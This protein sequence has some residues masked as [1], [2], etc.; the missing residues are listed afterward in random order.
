[1]KTT[2]PIASLRRGVLSVIASLAILGTASAADAAEYQIQKRFIRQSLHE[3]VKDQNK[4]DSLIRGVQVMK[5]RNNA[6]KNSVEYRTSW[7]YLGA[8]H[9]YP[10]KSS[11]DGTLEEVQKD[12]RQAFPDDAPL[13]AGFFDGLKNLTPPEQPRGVAK[14]P[15]L[16]ASTGPATFSLGTGWLSISSSAFSARRRVILTLLCHIGIIRTTGQTLLIRRTRHG[17]CQSISFLRR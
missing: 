14:K 9:G 13:Y 6:P 7:E 15:G 5:S 8:I 10:G 2:I 16:L 11:R 1:M 4:L 17:G 12:L 3:F